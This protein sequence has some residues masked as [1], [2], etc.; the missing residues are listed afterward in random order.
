MAKPF[1]SVVIPALNEEK[2]IGKI[3][4]DLTSQTFKNFEV[5]VVDGQSLD[6]TTL[7]VNKFKKKYPISIISS[8]KKNLSLQRNLGAKTANGEY[9]FFIDADNRIP[10]NFLKITKKFIADNN[11]DAIIPKLLP[12]QNNFFNRFSYAVSQ[13]LVKISLLTPRPF[14]T[15]GNLIISKDTYFKTHGF[16]EK[17]FI[18]EDHDMVRQLK[19]IG[20]KVSLMT[21]TYVVF[22]MRRFTK[23]GYFTYIKYSYAFVYQIVFRKIDSK[24]YSYKMGGHLFNNEK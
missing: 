15:G 18:G 6:N 5:I 24:I 12:G 1:F 11:C 9:F 16:D 2:F 3:L 7:V 17:V 4:L 8:K 20:A 23:E 10:N 14:S 13:F 21:D 22:S 19:E